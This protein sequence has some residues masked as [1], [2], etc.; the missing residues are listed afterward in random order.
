VLHAPPRTEQTGTTTTGTTFPSLL[1]K[2]TPVPNE[3]RA[4]ARSLIQ[5]QGLLQMLQLVWA[6]KDDTRPYTTFLTL[7]DKKADSVQQLQCM[8]E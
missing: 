3:T 2:L 4:V 5:N 8:G 1:Q 6:K 7:D